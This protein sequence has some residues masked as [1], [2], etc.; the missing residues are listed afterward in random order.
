MWCVRPAVLLGLLAV[1]PQ[2]P[3][4]Q[5]P[6]ERFATLQSE[7]TKAEG[8]WNE[9]YSPGGKPTPDDETLV[10][11]RDWPTWSFLPKFMEFAEQN[12]KDPAAVDALLWIVDQGQAIGLTDKE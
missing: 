11:Y 7:Y 12:P 5:T 9:R 3:P 4:P 10:R 6:K 1:A 2:A 8:A